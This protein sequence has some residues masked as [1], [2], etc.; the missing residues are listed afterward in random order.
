[1]GATLNT[2]RVGDVVVMD[3]SGRITL[4]EGSSAMRGEIR[5]LADKGDKK[6]LLNLGGVTYID[7][8]GLGELVS[9]YTSM[10]HVGGTLKLLSPTKR[11]K[12]LLQI[13]HTYK[14]FE[15]HEDEAEAVR[16]FA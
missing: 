10:V 11:T 3:V 5:A 7:S 9:G 8:A 4:G 15:V 2:R 6:V 1:M 14:L 13:T 12:E 16:S